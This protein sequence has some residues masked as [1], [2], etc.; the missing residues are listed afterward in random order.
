MLLQYGEDGKGN[1]SNGTYITVSSSITSISAYYYTEDG[2]DNWYP[3]RLPHPTSSNLWYSVNSFRQNKPF[4]HNGRVYAEASDN[5]PNS[6]TC[7]TYIGT[8]TWNASGYYELSA[9]GRFTHDK[10]CPVNQFDKANATDSETG[11][12]DIINWFRAGSAYI[13]RGYHYFISGQ[14]SDDPIGWSRM[15][16]EICTTGPKVTIASCVNDNRFA[17]AKVCALQAYLLT[18]SDYKDNADSMVNRNTLPSRDPT[19]AVTIDKNDVIYAVGNTGANVIYYGD[20]AGTGLSQETISTTG[21]SPR[22]IN[23]SEQDGHRGEFVAAIDSS[24]TI[25]VR[26]ARTNI[27][28]SVDASTLGVTLA[29]FSLAVYTKGG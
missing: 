2:G 8:P 23:R 28:E 7:Y 12:V 29:P 16:E 14:S 4:L 5:V 10:C 25:K 26:D 15:P 6:Q 1:Y 13:R 24:E 22:Y 20:F 3:L 9:S 18:G 11:Y 19:Y 17:V 27:F 21:P